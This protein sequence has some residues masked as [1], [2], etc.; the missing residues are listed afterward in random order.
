[1]KD[2]DDGWDL[3]PQYLQYP[4]TMTGDIS[5]IQVSQLRK[6]YQYMTWILARIVGQ[7]STSTI[8]CLSLYILYFSIQ[9]KTIFNWSKIIS[10]EISFQL[11][12][13]KRDKTFY[14]SEYLI[15]AIVYCH[16]F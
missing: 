12:N 13:F 16:V 10:S 5:S 11:S 2:R 8:P 6:P 1:M 4:A 7:E 15:F 9:K 3:F 14:M